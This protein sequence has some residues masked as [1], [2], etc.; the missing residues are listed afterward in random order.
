MDAVGGGGRSRGP[1][2]GIAPRLR[3]GAVD[4]WREVDA[5]VLGLG[6]LNLAESGWQEG[7]A[8]G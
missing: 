7:G 2:N 8:Q 6:W 5:E 4:E 1:L 3:G